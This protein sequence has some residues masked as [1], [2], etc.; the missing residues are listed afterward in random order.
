MRVFDSNMLIY[1]LNDALPSN[2]RSRIE[3][4]ILE[5]A[6]ISVITRIEVLGF[7][8][9]EPEQAAASRLL[10]IFTEVPLTEPVVQET[11]RLRQAYRIRTPDAI[12]AATAHVLGCPLVTRNTR[13]FVAI[14]D[15]A[16][17][18]PFA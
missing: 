4:W 15:L 8:L 9:P 6:A 12:I 16:I 11:I 14:E 5:G 18:D 3:G 13:D 2:L 1:H 17:I 10:S 7:R